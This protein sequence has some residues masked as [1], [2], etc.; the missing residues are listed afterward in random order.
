MGLIA[1]LAMGTWRTDWLAGGIVLA[2]SATGAFLLWRIVAAAERNR[3]SRE[4]ELAELRRLRAAIE[5]DAGKVRGRLDE[6][7]QRLRAGSESLGFAGAPDARAVE[8]AQD[9]VER[10]L[11]TA[12]RRQ[13]TVQKRDDAKARL[14]RAKQAVGPATELDARQSAQLKAAESEW[15]QWLSQAGLPETLSPESAATVLA[16]LDAAREQLNVIMTDRE[17]V[18]RMTAAMREYARQVVAAAASCGLDAG[19]WDNAGAAVDLLE[20]RLRR[21]RRRSARWTTPP[22]ATMKY[23]SRWSGPARERGSPKRLTGERRTPSGSASK[24]GRHS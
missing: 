24:R 23:T 15:R 20:A 4:Q 11:E 10:T 7:N 8:K 14:D 18:S 9:L 19:P 16:K 17:R 5:E 1:F 6:L 22:V 12:Q 21:M 13:P 3:S 2:L